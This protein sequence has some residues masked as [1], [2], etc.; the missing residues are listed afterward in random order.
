M[1]SATINFRRKPPDAFPPLLQMYDRRRSVQ[2]GHAGTMIDRAVS[3]VVN[4]L[5]QHLRQR[6][7]ISDDIVAATGLTD[8][9]GRPAPDARNRL[10]VFVC[11]LF[12]ETSAR[13]VSVRSSGGSTRAAVTAES[14]Y[15]NVDLMFASNFDPGNYLESLKVLSQAVE[16][17]QTTP[18]FDH[19]NA[20]EMDGRLDRL[21]LEMVNLSTDATNQIWSMHGGRYLP[22]VVYRMRLIAIRGG[23]MKA[24]DFLIRTP[25]G[26]ATTRTSATR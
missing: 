16:F 26:T 12:E 14:I 17:F 18:V 2:L 1:T 10:V 24:E 8:V 21:G 9:D 3:L 23:D 6:F 19:V 20:P 5:N 13:G 4:R 7:Q 22:S 11:G 25:E 15:L